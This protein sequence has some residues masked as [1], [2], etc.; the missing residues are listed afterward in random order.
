MGKMGERILSAINQPS[1]Q[2]G[3]GQAALLALG[4]LQATFLPD[5]VFVVGWYCFLEA[6]GHV[7]ENGFPGAVGSWASPARGPL[8]CKV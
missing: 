2:P 7:T 3:V 4:L 1:P 6:R 8:W 5:P